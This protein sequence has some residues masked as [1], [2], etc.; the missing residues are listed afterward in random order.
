MKVQDIKDI[1]KKK[2]VTRRMSK[3]DLIRTILKKKRTMLL[4]LHS[5][6]RHAANCIAYGYRLQIII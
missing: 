6:F 2:G 4:L 5:L 3:T 1:A